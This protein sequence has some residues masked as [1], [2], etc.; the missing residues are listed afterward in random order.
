M[1]D[2][3]FINPINPEKIYQSLPKDFTAMEIT[4]N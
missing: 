2:V 1:L 3:A 4:L